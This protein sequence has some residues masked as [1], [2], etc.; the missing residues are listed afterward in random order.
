MDS[1]DV[2]NATE[3]CLYIAARRTPM[4]I[5][6]IVVSLVLTPGYSSPFIYNNN[7]Y[8]FILWL[9]MAA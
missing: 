6:K 9:Q 8:L 7:Y 1:V 3:I 2:L 5:E 4:H